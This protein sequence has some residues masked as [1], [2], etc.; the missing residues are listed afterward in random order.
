VQQFAAAAI[1]EA[2]RFY[3]FGTAVGFLPNFAK[4]LSG[5]KSIAKEIS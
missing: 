2:Q 1:T 4:E 5:W 3:G